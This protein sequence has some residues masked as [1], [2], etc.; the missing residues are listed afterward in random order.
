MAARCRNT[1]EFTICAIF[2]HARH[3]P[4]GSPPKT[5]SFAVNSTSSPTNR[6]DALLI[7][8]SRFKEHHRSEAVMWAT[9]VSRCTELFGQL[10]KRT[11]RPCASSH[12]MEHHHILQSVYAIKGQSHHATRTGR[13]IP[14][15][16]TS[17]GHNVSPRLTYTS[18]RIVS[19]VDHPREQ[20]RLSM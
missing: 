13:P 17:C 12:A 16:T 10:T 2:R 5:R 8:D 7:F 18:L 14:K 9:S 20:Y 3:A 15:S 11:E 1:L 4:N 6:S 19:M